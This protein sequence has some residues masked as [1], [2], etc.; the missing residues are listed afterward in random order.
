[1]AKSKVVT[2]TVMLYL[3]SIAKLL[4]PLATLPYLTRVLTEEAYGLVSYVK[5]CM[6]YMQLIIDFGFIYS[7]VKD[8]VNAGGDKKKIGQIAGNTFFSKLMLCVLSAV[9]LVVMCCCIRV[10]RINVLFVILSF[11]S[12]ATTALFGD[13]LFRGIEKMQFITFIFLIAKGVSTALTFVF[14]KNDGTLLWIPILDIISHL[15]SVGISFGIIFKLKIPIRVTKIV[16]CLRMIKESFFYFLSGVATTMLSALNTILIGIFITDLAKVAHWSLCFNIIA[17][18]QGLYAPICNG[19]YPHMI[20]KRSL[21]FIHKVLLLF[22]PI[23]TV[24]CIACFF[25]SKT[26]M[27][28]VGGE[29]YVVAHTLFRWMIP[30]L[31]FSFPAQVY[32]WPTLGAIGKVKATTASTV[33]AAITQVLLLAILILTHHFTLITVAISR[34]ISEFV[35]MG[36]RM[37]VAYRNK[38]LFTGEGE[39]KHV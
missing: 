32:G 5:S 15:I 19:I 16:D 21:R 7:S 37:F 1:M 13:F 27:L 22:M 34:I 6:T 23:V 35:L 2:N 33:A 36:V 29:K 20:R 12:V 11:V 9:A 3:I 10:L 17:A 39:V 24:G 4:F 26:A 18:I 28:V 31:F 14:V 30:I 8:I 25:L 38:A